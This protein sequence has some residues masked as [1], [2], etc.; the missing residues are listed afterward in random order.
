GQPHA[1]PVASDELLYVG[2]GGSRF[3][4]GGGEES[5]GAKPLFAVKAGATG[6]ISLKDKATSNDHVAWFSPQGGPSMASPILYEG[7]LYILEQR[8]GLLSCLDAK[9]GKQIY[10]E[11]LGGRGFTSSPWAY[12]G[13]IFCLGDDGQTY[14]VQAGTEFKLLGKNGIGE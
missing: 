13:K 9:T 10:K 2:T 7:H 6:D 3:N 5:R 8:G 4:A 11:R 1:T 14:V 12:D